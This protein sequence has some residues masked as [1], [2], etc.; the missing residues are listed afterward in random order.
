MKLN[1]FRY[2]GFTLGKK[3]VVY[4]ILLFVAKV[5]VYSKYKLC[6]S[7]FH[8]CLYL[9]AFAYLEEESTQL[10]NI[11]NR[12]AALKCPNL[13]PGSIK[14][15][16]RAHRD[17]CCSNLERHVVRNDYFIRCIIHLLEN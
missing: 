15:K 4:V 10:K 16:K 17:T 1:L 3:S 7:C 5:S 14:G 2:T 13:I 11:Q 12:F 8:W 9:H 6:V